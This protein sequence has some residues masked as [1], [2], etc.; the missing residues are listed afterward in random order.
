M[1]GGRRKKVNTVRETGA[2]PTGLVLVAV[3]VVV[4]VV[5]LVVRLWNR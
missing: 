3:I 4:L 5:V 1:C 2:F